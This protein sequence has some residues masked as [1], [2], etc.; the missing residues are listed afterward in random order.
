M[1]RI[2]VEFKKF[3]ANGRSILFASGDSGV[4]CN[5]ACNLFIPDFPASS[6]YITSVGGIVMNGDQDFEGDEISS[7]GFSNIFGMPSYQTA[8]VQAFIAQGNLPP[9]S[10]WN[11]SGRAMP[12]ICSFSEDVDIMYEGSLSGVGGTSCAAP[13]VSAII[14]LINDQRLQA[15]K[16]TLGFLNPA[17]YQLLA[18]HPDAFFDITT[19]SN[20]DGCCPGFYATTGWDPITGVGAPNFA[21]L[22]KYLIAL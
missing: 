8:A 5:T 14:S 21:T 6:P 18:K 1:D 20:S 11:A 15:G 19:G 7:G 17:L 9:Q 3:G 13:V 4:G 10:F 2:N 12:D 22:S 16:K